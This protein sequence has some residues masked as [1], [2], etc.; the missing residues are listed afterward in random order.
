MPQGNTIIII[1]YVGYRINYIYIYIYIFIFIHFI[2][3]FYQ[4]MKFS[5]WNSFIIKLF[6]YTIYIF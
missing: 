2:Y 5:N 4:M 1:E 3:I 6:F